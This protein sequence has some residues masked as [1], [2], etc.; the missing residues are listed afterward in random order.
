VFIE[1]G[2]NIN[3]EYISHFRFAD[4]IVIMAETL[5]D[6]Q[7]MLNDLGDSS[8]SIGLRMNLNKA[9]VMFNKHVLP[10]PIPI[11]GAILE[12]VQKYVYLGQTLQNR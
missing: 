4:A 6:L 9:K 5:Q 7:L 12:V 1:C 3:G 11:R 10:K 2:I 8:V